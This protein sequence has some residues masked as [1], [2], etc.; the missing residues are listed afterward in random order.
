[1]YLVDLHATPEQIDACSTFAQAK[2]L[3]DEL[4]T[5]L[6]HFQETHGNEKWASRRH[7]NAMQRLGVAPAAR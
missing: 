7:Y 3:L 6:R 2:T 5:E 4:E 1:M